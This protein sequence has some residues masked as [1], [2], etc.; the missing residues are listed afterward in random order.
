MAS[1]QPAWHPSL[2][3]IQH[4]L[5]SPGSE[6]HPPW[7]SSGSS[8]AAVSMQVQVQGSAGQP[9]NMTAGSLASCH[10][11]SAIT[12]HHTCPSH[13]VAHSPV[14]GIH[15]CF[16]ARLWEE[17][18]HSKCSAQGASML[19]VPLSCRA[20]RCAGALPGQ[21]SQP[22]KYYGS[23]AQKGQLQQSPNAHSL[24]LPCRTQGPPCTP[25]SRGS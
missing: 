12:I 4:E 2:P 17:Q 11:T 15:G 9:P 24:P 13:M 10:A 22:G 16:P 20:W 7:A 21:R 8:V 19:H 18:Q 25:H 5:G 14:G 23:P 1:K 3:C 6:A